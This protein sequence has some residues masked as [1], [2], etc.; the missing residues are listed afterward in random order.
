MMPEG[1]GLGGLQM[2]EARHHGRGVR[3]RLVAKR[4][5]KPRDKVQDRVDLVPDIKTEVGGHLVVAR[6][7]CMQ[8]AGNRPDELGEP[9]L[10]IEMDV[11]ELRLEVKL[12]RLDLGRDLVE[13][14]RDGGGFLRR[15]DAGRA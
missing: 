8:L 13:A 2:G 5:L 4:E 7:R 6:P 12:A 11:L 9:A 14:A 10:D 1:D 3:F 15:Q